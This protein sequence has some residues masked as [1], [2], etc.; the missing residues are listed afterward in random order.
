MSP[1]HKVQ[2]WHS[3]SNI[4]RPLPS[5]GTRIRE[6]TGGKEDQPVLQGLIQYDLLDLAGTEV[7]LHCRVALAGASNAYDGTAFGSAVFSPIS[8]CVQNKWEMGK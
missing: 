1:L 4:I 2:S 5:Q 8:Y 6:P 3:R 7:F